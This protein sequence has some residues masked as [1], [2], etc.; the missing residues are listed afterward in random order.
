V[1][2]FIGWAFA[3]H[4]SQTRHQHYLMNHTVDIDGDEAHSETYYM[5]VGTDRD[6]DKPLIVSGGRYVDRLAR[7]EDRW[8]IAAR[9]CLSSGRA[10][11]V[12][13]YLRRRSRSSIRSRPCRASHPTP[14]TTVR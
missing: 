9:V 8:A 7:R 10:R 3:Y 12:R 1:D 14:H 5:F 2:D 13:C 6:A 4:A 11:R